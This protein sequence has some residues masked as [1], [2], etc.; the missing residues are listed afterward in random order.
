ML[1]SAVP[2]WQHLASDRQS[3]FTIC[4]PF[5][6]ATLRSDPYCPDKQSAVWKVSGLPVIR[7]WG[8]FSQHKE[9]HQRYVDPSSNSSKVLVPINGQG[10]GPKLWNLPLCITWNPL[11]GVNFL[12]KFP[13]IHSETQTTFAGGLRFQQ[14]WI[15]DL[16][17]SRNLL[18]Q[19]W[20]WVRVSPFLW[21]V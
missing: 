14:L 19:P 18:N 1:G 7:F 5:H 8:L 11:S 12:K 3:C 9:S 2:P 15:G 6:H 13:D 16:L 4:A 17:G 20:R 21:M 10:K